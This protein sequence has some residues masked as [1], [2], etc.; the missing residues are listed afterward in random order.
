MEPREPENRPK[1]GMGKTSN[2]LENLCPA[3]VFEIRYPSYCEE[4][5][6]DTLKFWIFIEKGSN[7]L[8]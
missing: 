4:G 7:F 1:S 6:G 2:S 8:Q 3:M 5:Y